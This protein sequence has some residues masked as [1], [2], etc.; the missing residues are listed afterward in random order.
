M[1][2]TFSQS[3]SATL[4]FW[5]KEWLSR[6]QTLQKLGQSDK[7]KKKTEKRWTKFEK[8]KIEKVEKKLKSWKRTN[9]FLAALAA[10]YLTLVSDWV[11]GFLTGGV[12]YHTPFH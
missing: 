8:G 6:L 1:L 11:T 12:S 5:H 4:E 7:L 3:L 10:P 2:S 9:W